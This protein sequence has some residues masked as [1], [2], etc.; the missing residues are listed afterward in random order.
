MNNLSCLGG[1]GRG[2]FVRRDHLGRERFAFESCLLPPRHDLLHTGFRF[3]VRDVER[4]QFLAKHV[5]RTG[6][7]TGVQFALSL[8]DCLPFVEQREFLTQTIE[9]Y[10]QTAFFRRRFRRPDNLLKR[11]DLFPKIDCSI[12]VGGRQCTGR[13]HRKNCSRAPGAT[14]R[15][16][17]AGQV[18]SSKFL[19]RCPEDKCELART[20]PA[21]A[22][23]VTSQ[24]PWQFLN[25]F[26]LPHG[27]GSLRP[28][29][30]SSRRMVTF[31]S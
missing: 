11:R 3:L 18:H 5:Q 25:F 14:P 4:P 21:P 24:A 8:F 6:A 17:E 10:G 9:L 19:K 2:R 23:P 15:R 22:K 28:T 16:D 12:V 13:K 26:P 20:S 29:F 30:G 31:G 7:A 27:Q 1:S